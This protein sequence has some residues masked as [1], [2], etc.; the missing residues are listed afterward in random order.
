MPRQACWSGW[1]GVLASHVV[2][3]LEHG[4]VDRGGSTDDLPRHRHDDDSP[5][6]ATQPDSIYL[7][8]LVLAEGELAN[9]IS[10]VEVGDDWYRVN[11]VSDDYEQ[12]LRGQ[13]ARLL[14]TPAAG[15]VTAAEGMPVPGAPG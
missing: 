5:H 2:E 8:R 6:P 13:L 4:A 12:L 15:D 7:T 14:P 3:H 1:R 11:G 10:I 9:R